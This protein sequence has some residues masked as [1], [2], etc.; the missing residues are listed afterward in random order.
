MNRTHFKIAHMK[1]DLVLLF[2]VFLAACGNGGNSTTGT[3]KGDPKELLETD[4]E[5]SKMC[6]EK[7]IKESFLFY[8]ADDVI[9]LRS[10]EAAVMGKEELKKMYD[11]EDIT[12]PPVMTWEPLKADISASGDMGF[13]FGT[14]KMRISDS[15]S[16]GESVY[17]GNYLSVWKKMSDG[18]WK[19]VAEASTTTPAKEAP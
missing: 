15:I 12:T 7:G 4:K 16:A 13:T 19:Y 5:F 1:K 10:K 18:K 14:W 6:V 9:K 11:E 8:A 17:T 2:T 3:Q